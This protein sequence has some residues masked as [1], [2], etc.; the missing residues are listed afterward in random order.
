MR[1]IKTLT[2][3]LLTFSALMVFNQSATTA[4]TTAGQAKVSGGHNAAG[5][6]PKV[7]DELN[8]TAEQKAKLKPIYED[9]AK[10]LKAV[11]DDT[12][13]S[14]EDKTAK[15]KEIRQATQKQ[16][17]EILTPEQ[18]QQMRELQQKAKAQAAQPAAQPEQKKP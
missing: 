15:M 5:T 17:R 12:A 2:I 14:Q 8:L 6:M 16:V 11:R 13:L 9:Q 3:T 7:M 4:Q 10:Q 18:R 1:K